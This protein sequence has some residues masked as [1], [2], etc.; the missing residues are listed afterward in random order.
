M[1]R[2]TLYIVQT[3]RLGRRNARTADAPVSCQSAAAA[4]RSAT[5][6]TETLEVIPR[7]WKVIQTVRE[8]F[9]YRACEAITQPP[10]PFHPISRGRAGPN[11]LAMILTSESLWRARPRSA[12]TAASHNDDQSVQIGTVE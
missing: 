5:R 2:Q 4:C 12:R 10:A 6:L 7:Q 3:F 1:A 11:L 9:S 8:K